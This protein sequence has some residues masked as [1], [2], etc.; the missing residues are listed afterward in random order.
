MK[1]V[2]WKPVKRNSQSDGAEVKEESSREGEE[3][4]ETGSG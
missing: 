3:T 2:A 1:G 4:G